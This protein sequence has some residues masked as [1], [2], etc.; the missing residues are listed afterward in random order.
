VIELLPN[1]GEAKMRTG[2]A[3]PPRTIKK[4]RIA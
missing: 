3:L 1:K 2:Q 4:G